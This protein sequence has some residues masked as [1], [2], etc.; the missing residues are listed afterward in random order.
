MFRFFVETFVIIDYYLCCLRKRYNNNFLKIVFYC[1]F[2][3][4]PFS[5]SFIRY[6]IIGTLNVRIH[7]NNDNDIILKFGT[8]EWRYQNTISNL[9]TNL[10]NLMVQNVYGN[11][12]LIIMYILY[13]FGVWPFGIWHV[14]FHPSCR[15]IAS[16][17]AN[18]VL[19]IEWNQVFIHFF[20]LSLFILIELQNVN[21]H[22][23]KHKMVPSNA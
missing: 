11:P 21:Q 16:G 2:I 3:R 18:W 9:I 13:V 23:Q 15:Q 7:L 22:S 10:L 6:V 20:S 8:I 1:H 5:F 14:V 17:Y 12:W 19:H 4:S